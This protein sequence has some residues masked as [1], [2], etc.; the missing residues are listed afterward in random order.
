ML[1]FS[2]LFTYFYQFYIRSCTSKL[3]IVPLNLLTW[4]KLSGCQAS[5][6]SFNLISARMDQIGLLHYHLHWMSVCWTITA[7]EDL[8]KVLGIFKQ[9]E[10]PSSQPQAYQPPWF[11]QVFCHLLRASLFALWP[12]NLE[13]KFLLWIAKDWISGVKSQQ[14][15]GNPQS[16]AAVPTHIL[17]R[18]MRLKLSWYIPGFKLN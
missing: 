12:F 4:R 2:S 1:K 13:L 9:R 16:Q 14:I 10:W 18:F 8:L 17:Y 15:S 11:I 3:A 6:F 5:R 7:S